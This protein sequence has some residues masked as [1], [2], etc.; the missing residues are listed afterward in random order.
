MRGLW[1]KDFYLGK[2]YLL[3]G[4]VMSALLVFLSYWM[5]LAFIYGN[6]ALLP[7]ADWTESTRSL[8]LVL[9]VLPGVALLFIG[10]KA[11]NV[12]VYADRQAGW[13]SY[14]RASPLGERVIVVSKYLEFLEM[15]LVT[16]ALSLAVV[17]VYGLFFGFE[18]LQ[19]WC[20]SLLGAAVLASLCE[21][22]LLPVS[23]RYQSENMAVGFAFLGMM[24]PGYLAAGVVAVSI[25]DSEQVLEQY[26]SWFKSHL[27]WLMAA[28][29]GIAALFLALSYGISLRIV[30][31]RKWYW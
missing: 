11:V 25:S 3:L 10:I 30:K 31:T 6:L 9:P 14:L 4:A 7:E 27:W 29:L 5:R 26:G 22:I 20:L 1:R 17:S 19:I 15:E 28:A 21:S 13:N 24:L 2:K 8:D 16:L 12:S 23:Y 18:R